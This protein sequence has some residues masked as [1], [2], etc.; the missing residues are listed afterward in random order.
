MLAQPGKAVSQFSE[1][2]VAHTWLKPPTMIRSEGIPFS[3]SPSMSRW[4]CE[5]EKQSNGSCVLL[6]L[7]S[8][9]VAVEPHCGC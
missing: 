9:T 2:R 5:A 3:T 7:K 1:K 8:P 4:T 6:R